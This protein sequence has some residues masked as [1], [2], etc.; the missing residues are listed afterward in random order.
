[1]VLCRE[2]LWSSDEKI[3]AHNVNNDVLF[4]ESANFGTVANKIHIQKVENFSL[5]PG[6][7]P[8][9]VLCYVPGIYSIWM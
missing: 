9:H 3:C 7:P 2:P 1:M 6:T 4:Y 8:Y 5:A